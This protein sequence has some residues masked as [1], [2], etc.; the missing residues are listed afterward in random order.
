[1]SYASA[2]MIW[3]TDAGIVHVLFFNT[4]IFMACLSYAK[5]ITTHPGFAPEDWVPPRCSEARLAEAKAKTKKPGKKEIIPPETPRW[6]I[7]CQLWKPPRSSHCKELGGCVLRMDHFCPWVDNCVGYRNHKSF[8]L[9]LMYSVITLID[10][11]ISIIYRLI[12]DASHDPTMIGP[13]DIVLFFYHFMITFPMTIMIFGLFGYQLSCLLEN[14]T[15]VETTSYD[16]YR[17]LY[18]RQKLKFY[19]IYDQ[20]V[21]ANLRD[22]CGTSFLEWWFPVVPLHVQEGSGTTWIMPRP[23][24]NIEAPIKQKEEPPGVPDSVCIEIDASF[25]RK[26]VKEKSSFD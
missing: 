2:W 12:W 14:C 5:T 25:K 16:N 9:F 10:F 15:A 7:H 21:R 20:G 22:F 26:A 13:F 24:P 17:W 3:A 11:L 8:M 19:W 4:M 1:M 23:F 18:K 6:C